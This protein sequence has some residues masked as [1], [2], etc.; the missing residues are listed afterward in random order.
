MRREG[1]AKKTA[2]ERVQ[3]FASAEEIM[4]IASKVPR[5]K[6]QKTTVRFEPKP[7]TLAVEVK[8]LAI[9]ATAANLEG[10]LKI[11]TLQEQDGL[12]RWRCSRSC[13]YHS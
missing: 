9:R 10:V 8:R 1:R 12:L 4:R 11:S 13:L 6:K 3:G 5:K 2:I 7:R